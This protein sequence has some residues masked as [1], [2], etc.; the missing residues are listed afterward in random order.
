MKNKRWWGILTICLAPWRRNLARLAT[1][2][3][4]SR[5]GGKD[6]GNELHMKRRSRDVLVSGNISLYP[7]IRVG[8]FNLHGCKGL[9]NRVMSSVRQNAWKTS[10]SLLWKKF[11]DLVFSVE[12]IKRH[13][14]G[15]QLKMAW[16][17][18]PAVR[19]WY[20]QESGNGFLTSLPVTF[21]SESHC[22]RTAIT[23][24][25]MWFCWV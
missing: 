6:S 12:K 2:A 11:T 8:T 15:K 7:P 5:R 25:G 17:F 13:C 1:P 19:E 14:L 24:F 4:R 10:I 18:T 3:N 16:L 20:C 9:D 21:W 22:N 23:A